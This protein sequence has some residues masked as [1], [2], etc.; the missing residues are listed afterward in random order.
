MPAPET[1]PACP[2]KKRF[3]EE[4]EQALGRVFVLQRDELDAVINYDLSRLEQIEGSSR[5]PVMKKVS[6]WMPSIFTCAGTSVRRI[7]IREPGC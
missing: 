6:C 7:R 3:V 2:T 5:R 1:A 4:I